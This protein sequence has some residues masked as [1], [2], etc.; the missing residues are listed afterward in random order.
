LGAV[1]RAQNERGRF[2]AMIEEWES[3]GKRPDLIVLDFFLDSGTVLEV[4]TTVVERYQNQ[5]P[6]TILLTSAQ[7][8][9]DMSA[10]TRWMPIIAKPFSAIHLSAIVAA[11]TSDDDRSFGQRFEACL[12]SAQLRAG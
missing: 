12:L 4:W 11:L 7:W 2:I 6:A 5:L 9:H 10:L 1:V 8:Q 3:C